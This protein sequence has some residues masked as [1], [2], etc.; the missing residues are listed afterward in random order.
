MS[1]PFSDEVNEAHR[2]EMTCCMQNSFL[3]AEPGLRPRS[4]FSVF[5]V[6]SVYYG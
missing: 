2:V 4:P 3:T 6:L 5:R 1:A